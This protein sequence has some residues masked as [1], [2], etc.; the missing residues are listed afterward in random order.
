MLLNISLLHTGPA[1]INNPLPNNTTVF[2]RQQLVADEPAQYPC[3]A[4]GNPPP[5]VIWYYNG[6]ALRSGNGVVVSDDGSLL[7]SSLQVNHSGI[8]QCVAENRFGEDRRTWILEVREG[9]KQNT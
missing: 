4:S 3:V 2:D 5:N 9:S 6:E 7:I 1:T 8:Y